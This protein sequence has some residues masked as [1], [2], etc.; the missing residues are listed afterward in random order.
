MQCVV[1]KIYSYVLNNRLLTYLENQEL[2]VDEQNG[3][4]KDRS[5]LDHVFTLNSVTQ[6][7]NSSFV[8]FI[9]LQKAFDSVDRELLEYRLLSSGIDGNFYY[10]VKSLYKNSQ[11]CVRL[12]EGYTNWFG[13]N[14]GVRQGDNLSLTLFALYI[15]D[16]AL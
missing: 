8:A 4:R 15:N 16:L 9:D 6:N 1:A 11:S 3:F 5:C 10:A 14:T 7:T 2:L 13:C 12:G